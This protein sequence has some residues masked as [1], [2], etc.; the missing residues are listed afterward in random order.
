[1]KGERV[2][3]KVE[4][5]PEAWRVYHN[6]SDDRRGKTMREVFVDI[7][8]D[9]FLDAYETRVGDNEYIRYS[10]AHEILYY[11]E[12]EVCFVKHIRWKDRMY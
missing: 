5:S 11:V 4:L 2:L 1:M 7:M 3:R 10:S 9:P 12:G 8:I 6:F